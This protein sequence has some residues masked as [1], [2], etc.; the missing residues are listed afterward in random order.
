MNKNQALNISKSLLLQFRKKQRTNVTT[1]INYVISSA[2]SSLF[3]KNMFT[4]IWC[5]S[6][7]KLQMHFWGQNQAFTT[8][9]GQNIGSASICSDTH[10]PTPLVSAFSCTI[11]RTQI[12]TK[13]ERNNVTTFIH[14]QHYEYGIADQSHKY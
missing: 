14:C 1:Q 9:S 2:V 10:D 6:L 5:L 8:L 12:N 13:M 3:T 7:R 4:F 11:K